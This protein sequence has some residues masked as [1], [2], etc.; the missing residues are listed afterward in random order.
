MADEKIVLEQIV[1]NRQAIAATR[2]FNKELDRLSN[3]VLKGTKTVKQAESSLYHYGKALGLTAERQ[4]QL[5]L[6][7]NAA[8]KSMVRQG[9]SARYLGIQFGYLI[10]DMNYG[11]LGIANNVSQVGVS[12]AAAWD[13]AGGSVKRFTKSLKAAFSGTNLVLILF[14]VAVA[15]WQQWAMRAQSAA[16]KTKQFRDE[17]AGPKGLIHEL[18]A[19]AEMMG[20]TNLSVDAQRVALENLKREG[21]D[22]AKQ[23]L[24][25][26]LAAK[27]R[28]LIF[29]A[30]KTVL[31]KELEDLITEQTRLQQAK[32]KLEEDI[33]KRQAVT[34]PEKG[35]LTG[36]VPGVTPDIEPGTTAAQRA[37]LQEVNNQIDE[38]DRKIPE[39]TKKINDLV[40]KFLEGNP[41]LPGKDSSG[42]GGSKLRDMFKKYRESVEEWGKTFDEVINIRFNRTVKEIEKELGRGLTTD[43]RQLLLDYFAQQLQDHYDKLDK[44][45]EERLRRL[46]ERAVKESE[47]KERA[48]TRILENHEE[49]RYQ[50]QLQ[51][52]ER[53]RSAKQGFYNDLIAMG[54]VFGKDSE[55]IMLALLGLEKGLAIAEIWANASAESGKAKTSA[56]AANAAA[57]AGATAIPAVLPPGIPN[58]AKPIAEF[59]AAAGKAKNKVQ[60]G[61]TLTSIK[62]A[63]TYATAG[64]LAQGITGGARILA[65]PGGGSGGAGAGAS[66][67]P[68]F[69]IIGAAGGN[70][71]RETIDHR[72]R[73]Q[74]K[75]PIKAYVVEGEA[76][77]A[78]MAR[79]DAENQTTFG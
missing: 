19:W 36:I 77:A 64:V 41:F 55:G 65:S 44:A 3:E 18:E 27:K 26:F 5:Q 38:I 39:A 78:R 30:T 31:R 73:E 51:N 48:L 58:P 68:N 25:E 14:Q 45:E 21:Y 52:Q 29:E 15:L 62:T 49:R 2:K 79:E 50:I 33:K 24:E 22:P 6:A 67:E 10:S 11:V 23:S 74:G 71:L 59:A 37:E 53:I 72:L 43:E 4:K 13:E 7:A 60:L 40:K 54:R 9:Q 66:R 16:S 70:Q 63:A 47:R 56:A 76:Q 35:I 32:E 61:K 20:D 28:L 46:Y 1:E 17:L 69:N 42:S 12:M 75:E 8:T 34:T 57:T